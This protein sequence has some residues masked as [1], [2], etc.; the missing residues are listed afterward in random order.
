M[1]RNRIKK[2][3]EVVHKTKNIAENDRVCIDIDTLHWVIAQN[4]SVR[5]LLT[6]QESE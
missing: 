3:Q 1:L 2:K 6:G 5:R 4:L